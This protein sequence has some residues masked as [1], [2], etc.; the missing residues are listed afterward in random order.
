MHPA[1]SDTQRAS[2]RDAFGA[3]LDALIDRYQAAGALHPADL[4]AALEGRA[5]RQRQHV[6]A[7]QQADRAAL[8]R[9]LA[10]DR[11]LAVGTLAVRLGLPAEAVSDILRGDVTRY[12]AR[13]LSVLAFAAEYPVLQA[14][15]AAL[16][17]AEEARGVAVL[18]PTPVAVGPVVAKAAPQ[19][20]TIG[21]K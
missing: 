5:D 21:G 15:L 6:A 8:A 10:S 11:E 14:E 7:R 2:A 17:R 1:I 16:Q 19:P 9:E 20:I 13:R 18:V 12:D 3:E 4:T